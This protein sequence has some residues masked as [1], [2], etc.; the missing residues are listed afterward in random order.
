MPAGYQR[1]G[2]V[3]ILRLPSELRPYWT[4]LGA[5]WRQELGVATVLVRSGPIEGELRTPR[6]ERIAGDG[7]ETEVVEHGIRWRFDAAKIMF[8]AG[9][10]TER[11]RAGMLVTPGETVIDLFAGIGYFAIPAAGP[12]RAG[13]VLAVDKNPL[14]IRYLT[15]NAE[16]NGVRDRVVPVLGDNRS[17][18]LPSHE[19]DRIF[20]GV[21][22]SSLPWIPRAVGLLKP[23]GWI[24]VH[25]V[26]E[27]RDASA[28]A[29]AAAK[30]AIGEA[31]GTPLGEPGAREVKPYGPGRIHVVVD[32]RVGLGGPTEP[33][34]RSPERGAGSASP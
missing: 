27:A 33:I 17:V 29:V 6:V 16:R 25:S 10:R 12:G 22:P 31:G 1:L 15:E 14:A 34:A 19:A 18:P 4:E 3:L 24:H 28:R 30:E 8:A 20:L 26:E 13:R 32:V 5:A 23:G 9:N 2:R 21:L 11:R 7:T